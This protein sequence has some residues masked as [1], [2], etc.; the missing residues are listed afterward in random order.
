[1]LLSVKEKWFSSPKVSPDGKWILVTGASQSNNKIWNTDL[2]VVRSDGTNFTQL[3]YHPGN[4]MSGVWSPDGKS[5]YFVSQ[6]GTKNGEYNVWK[7][8]FP[9]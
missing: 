2:F 6:R 7:M 3:T 4:D 8:N 1:L 5:I 9:L